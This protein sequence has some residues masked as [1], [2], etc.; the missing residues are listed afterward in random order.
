AQLT[1]LTY[2]DLHR[3]VLQWADRAWKWLWPRLQFMALPAL[4]HARGAT[5]GHVLWLVRRV[6]RLVGPVQLLVA[7][8]PVAG[9]DSTLP[10]LL[11]HSMRLIAAGS[12][13]TTSTLVALWHTGADRQ[14]TLR[15]IVAGLSRHQLALTVLGRD[16]SETAALEASF[17][18]EVAVGSGPEVARI[19]LVA[20]V[21]AFED[22][23]QRLL[24]AGYR[25]ILLLAGDTPYERL[26]LA[27]PELLGQ[28]LP[29]WPLPRANRLINVAELMCVA[30]ERP[31]SATEVEDWQV[32]DHVRKLTEQ[33]Q[34]QPLATDG[35]WQPAAVVSDP[36]ERIDPHAVRGQAIGVVDAS[37]DACGHVTPGVAERWGLVGAVWSP[38]RVVESSGKVEVILAATGEDHATWP[39]EV[40]RVVV[41]DELA[42]RS[43]QW[44]QH[45][46]EL[47]RIT[48]HA[49]ARVRGLIELWPGQQPREVPVARTVERQ[50][51]AVA[52]AL[53][54]E[55]PEGH[56]AAGWAL[57]ATLPVVVNSSPGALL[58][59][60]DRAQAQLLL[61]EVDPGGV[62]LVEALYTQMERWLE[63]AQQLAQ[64]C[65]T[66]SLYAPFAAPELQWLQALKLPAVRPVAA[67]EQVPVKEMVARTAAATVEHKPQGEVATP[68][69][70]RAPEVPQEARRRGPVVRTYSMPASAVP[71]VALAVPQVPPEL[72]NERSD[73]IMSSPVAQ[74]ELPME[75]DAPLA[76]A[77]P[78]PRVEQVDDIAWGLD[79]PAGPEAVEDIAWEVDVPPPL[80]FPTIQRAPVAS[81]EP[82]RRS[83]PPRYPPSRPV[84][85][86]PRQVPPANNGV[87]T[88]NEVRRDIA[89]DRPPVEERA[90]DVG[91]MIAR[92][93]QLRTTRDSGAEGSDT[94]AR[95]TRLPDEPVEPRFKRGDRVQCV[96]YGEGRVVE[97][98]VIGGREQLRIDFGEDGIIEVDPVISLVRQV[99]Q[100]QI[101][102]SEEEL[103]D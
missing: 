66:Y 33:G 5:G 68:L 89:P 102:T 79:A 96:P 23:R 11:G 62:G 76:V 16:H 100:A 58:P 82:M 4:H 41:R 90:G 65:A 47:R 36:Y 78:K 46:L 1:L 34:L 98:V 32:A 44:K 61:I 94:P 45:R 84:A 43:L 22:D 31:I 50:W 83:T 6:E 70:Q 12:G 91:G 69:P 54:A 99:K 73:V 30:S 35:E 95:G 19:A 75:V 87:P 40:V 77:E 52:L 63:L 49:N 55:I 86:P 26:L 48:V 29:A 9:A 81:R 53:P 88:R 74:T 103:S 2:D 21:P 24:R 17:Q 42:K 80:A 57:L 67:R 92:L 97:S 64:A 71:S 8:A 14:A 60:Y 93:R 37:G 13:P 3:R 38:G 10:R 72:E 59:W 7:L 27:Q 28:T 39:V 56:L 18:A 25:L 20:G 85:L 15:Q 51:E 101:A